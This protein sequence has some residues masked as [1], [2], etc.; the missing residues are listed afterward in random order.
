M[1]RVGA[2]AGLPILGASLGLRYAGAAWLPLEAA[3]DF[4]VALTAAWIVG[5]V[6]APESSVRFLERRPLVYLGTI[7]YGVYLFHGFVPYVL[8]RYVAGL[9]EM[10][11][12]ATLVLLSSVTITAASMS[13][14]LFEAPILGTRNA[15]GQRASGLAGRRARGQSGSR[16]I[17]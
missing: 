14:F 11:W 17:R 3:L 8:G 5:T 6:S 7:S 12:P 13:W 1:M 4:G 2:V 10:P 15:S 9:W 16:A